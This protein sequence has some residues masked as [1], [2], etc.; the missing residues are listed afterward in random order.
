MNGVEQNFC[1]RTNVSR[2]TIERLRGFEGLLLKWNH[3][4]NLVSKSTISEVWNRHFLDSAQ[5]ARYL[6]EKGGHWVDIGSGG[7]F[8]GI[9][10]AILAKE[11]SGQT[12]FTL[13]ESDSR[14]SAFLITVARELNLDVDVIVERVEN[15]KPQ[16][17]DIL[18]ARALASL[19]KLLEFSQIHL[20]KGGVCV[21]PK[22][23]TF[24]EEIIHAREL[25]RFDVVEHQSITNANSV[26]LQIGA[27]ER[28]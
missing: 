11:M 22:G 5:L 4:I 8:P 12:R 6:P 27:I 20:K 23:K 16:D 7:G 24:Q 14:K 18:S 13:I 3:A 26:I 25:W 28:V 21:F 1:N 17:A 15:A 2:E 19:S 9:V 10:L